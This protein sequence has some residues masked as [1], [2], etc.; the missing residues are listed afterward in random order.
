MTTDLAEAPEIKE[1]LPEQASQMPVPRGYKLLIGLPEV[2][3][4]TESGV[5]RGEEEVRFEGLSTIVGYVVSMGPDAYVD[6][7]KFPNGP[8]CKEEDWIIFRA[9]SG[10]RIK[11]HGVEFRLINDDMVEAVVR[12]PSGIKKA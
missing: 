3:E 10:T 6:S 1:E 12:D 5:Y 4:D 8:Y 2:K 11:V 7:K 9:F